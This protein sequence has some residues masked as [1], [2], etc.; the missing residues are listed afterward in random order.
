L[1]FAELH[2]PMFCRRQAVLQG[3]NHQIEAGVY[4]VLLGLRPN[5]LG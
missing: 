2:H 3:A 5:W 4:G 1:V